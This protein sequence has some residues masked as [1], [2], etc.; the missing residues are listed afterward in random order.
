MEIRPRRTV[1]TLKSF[2][3]VPCHGNG[4][5]CFS[6]CP[7]CGRIVLICDEVSH[8]YP[9]PHDLSQFYEGWLDDQ[10]SL[11][12]GCGKVALTEFRD[13]TT[14]EIERI[15]FRQGDYERLA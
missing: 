10:H 2:R 6:A 11:C 4:A 5:L 7:D 1:W 15:D 12:P 8:V 3:C 14:D 13:C 9:N